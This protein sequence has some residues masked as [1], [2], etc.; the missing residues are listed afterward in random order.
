MSIDLQKRVSCAHARQNRVM[1]GCHVS[2]SAHMHVH[3]HGGSHARNPSPALG[4]RSHDRSTRSPGQAQNE[5]KKMARAPAYHAQTTYAPAHRWVRKQAP[6]SV[7]QWLLPF[8][9]TVPPRSSCTRPEGGFLVFPLVF[10][11]CAFPPVSL[12]PAGDCPCRD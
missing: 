1:R 8:S 12:G 7:A 3:E 5:D 2:K 9:H 6:Q 10:G 11:G 4:H